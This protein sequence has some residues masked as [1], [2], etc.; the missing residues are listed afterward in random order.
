MKILLPVDGSA[1]TKKMLAYLTTH[2]ELCATGNSYTVL[3]AQP[4]LPPRGR[5][6]VGTEIAKAEIKLGNA[7][8]V[9]RAPASVVE[10]EKKRLA[11][12]RSKRD[13]IRAQL[14]RLA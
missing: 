7:S 11:D 8:F 3:P 14:A 6:A 12:F 13:D 2:P 9:E 4:P 10:Q 1:F 5:A